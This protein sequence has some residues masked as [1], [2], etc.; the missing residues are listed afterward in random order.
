MEKI[1]IEQGRKAF[2]RGNYATAVEF[3]STALR[4]NPL[5]DSAFAWRARARNGLQMFD[6]AFG[7]AQRCLELNPTNPMGKGGYVYPLIAQPIMHSAS[8]ST[9]SEI[10]KKRLLLTISNA[11]AF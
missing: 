4:M 10:S 6:L 5:S 8:F 2:V 7:D 11:I 1:E 3:F 9:K